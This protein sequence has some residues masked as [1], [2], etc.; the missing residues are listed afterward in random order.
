MTF[1]AA[2]QNNMDPTLAQRKGKKRR[3]PAPPNPFTGEIENGESST[4]PFDEDDTDEA[5][6]LAI[7]T[8]EV[9]NVLETLSL[10]V[11]TRAY[12]S[13]TE[14]VCMYACGHF[15]LS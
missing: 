10:I 1:Q 5:F 12:C 6:E 15:W 7:D 2:E 9:R 4:N 11:V 3:A 13:H 8:E 14:S